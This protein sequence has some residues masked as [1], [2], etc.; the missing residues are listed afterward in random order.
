MA[1][2]TTPTTTL[3]GEPPRQQAQLVRHDP[4]LGYWVRAGFGIGIGL[5]AGYLV[6][7][8]ITLIAVA[9]LGVGLPALF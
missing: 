6:L 5:V 2:Q 1:Q 9:L 4:P 3:Q 7:A 8:L